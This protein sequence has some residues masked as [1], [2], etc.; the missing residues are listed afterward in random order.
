M[1]KQHVILPRDQD[2]VIQ[3]RS[4]VDFRQPNQRDPCEPKP[5]Y[6]DL[7]GLANLAGAAAYQQ[8]QMQNQLSGAI[9]NPLFGS[10]GVFGRSVQ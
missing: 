2:E 1:K 10:L 3:L 6:G 8:Q 5:E 4:G 7:S 9:Q